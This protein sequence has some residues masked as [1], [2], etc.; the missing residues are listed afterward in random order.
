MTEEHF[1]ATFAILRDVCKQSGI[2]IRRRNRKGK[3]YVSLEGT[4]EEHK[5]W[6]LRDL[7]E[8]YFPNARGTSGST[9]APANVTMRVNL[10]KYDSSMEYAF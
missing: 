4:Q 9:T 1:I 6:T 2:K 7:V 3:F 10:P 5:Y 8:D